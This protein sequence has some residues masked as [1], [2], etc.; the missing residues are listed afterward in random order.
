ME[1]RGKVKWWE[2]AGC[3]LVAVVAVTAVVP[4]CW[5]RIGAWIA[6][7]DAGWVQAVGSILAILV[8]AGLLLAQHHLEQQRATD[9]ALADRVAR[10][11]IIQQVA[12]STASNARWLQRNFANRDRTLRIAT[13]QE[14]FPAD[15]LKFLPAAVAEIP[16]H[17]LDSPQ[18]VFEIRGLV[19]NARHLQA[20]IR[21][22]L[23]NHQLI[24]I[25][26]F[27]LAFTNIAQVARACEECADRIRVHVD[28][29]EAQGDEALRPVVKPWEEEASLGWEPN[30]ANVPN[31]PTV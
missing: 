18:L 24:D 19:F 4:G 31:V 29:V 11:R 22:M 21:F 7:W 2:V 1:R 26:V 25:G 13:G 8:S 6:T 28:A 5:P 16:L 10:M 12:M 27:Q 23:E 17:Q 9:S 15:A 14:F 20:Q 30:V 3:V